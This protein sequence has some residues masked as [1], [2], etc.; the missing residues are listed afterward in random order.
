[1][2]DA[3]S[4]D[5]APDL[6]LSET[7][8]AAIARLA[9]DEVV[10][11]PP[12]KL[13]RGAH[14]MNDD[15]ERSAAVDDPEVFW[16]ERAELIDWMRAVEH[17]ATIRAA[18]SRVVPRR[19][20]QRDVQLHRPPRPLRPP[21]QG[22]ADLGGRGRRR[23]HLHLQ[24]PLPRGEPL[25]QRPAASRR[26]EGRPGH[27][28]HAAGPRGHHHHA[29]LRAHRRHPLAWST[30][31]WAPRRL[32]SRI[33]DSGAKVIVASDFTFRRGKKIALKPTVDE[34]VRDLTFGGARRRPPPRF[35]PGR[36]ALCFRE[37]ARARLLR[38]PAGARDPLPAGADGLRAPAV[39]PLHLRHHRAA[40]RRRPRHRRLHGRG[41]LPVA[42]LL[43]DRR[44][45]HLLEHLGHRLDR[46]PFVH[47]LRAAVDR[48]HRV[49]PRGR[50]GLSLARG[51]L[52]A[53]RALRRQRHVHRADRAPDVDEPR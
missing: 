23:A 37:R 48:R 35:A 40:E 49:L 5:S 4:G 17:G 42:R 3:T 29:G 9:K 46:R 7:Q 24:P 43:P 15:I 32:R 50:A 47:R 22:G 13:A 16:A 36:R 25:R 44:A 1:M 2:S 27:P 21:Q 52:G 41:E 19:Q 10:I 18:A 6:E 28:L 8:R 53:G 20:A 11:K 33:V 31:A 26:G 34:A 12:L 30:P 51:H 39:H 38:H 45:R 14:L